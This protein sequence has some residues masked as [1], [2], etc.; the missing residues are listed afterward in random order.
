[1][2]QRTAVLLGVVFVGL[3]FL[4]SAP[5][6]AGDSAYLPDQGSLRRACATNELTV[7]GCLFVGKLLVGATVTP[8]DLKNL[9]GLKKNST[10]N[11]C[12]ASVQDFE[13]LLA[14]NGSTQNIQNSLLQACAYQYTDPTALGQCS[15]YV[16]DNTANL[17]DV[18]LSQYPPLVACQNLGYCPAN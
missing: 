15:A 7:Q 6:A 10:C 9:F 2:F 4:W 18:L 8:S 3:L 16:Q 5:A 17:I 13:V 14:T 11:A 1:M 12:I